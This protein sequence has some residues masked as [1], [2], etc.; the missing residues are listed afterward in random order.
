[1][2]TSEYRVSIHKIFTESLAELRQWFPQYIGYKIAFFFLALLIFTPFSALIF[3]FLTRTSSQGALTNE[4]VLS[5]LFSLRGV[6]S[7]FLWGSFT[8]FS[9]FIEQAGI[10]YICAY[11]QPKQKPP[12][13][14]TLK[15]LHQKR[16][17]ILKLGI[18][19][20]LR[21]LLF[22]LPFLLVWGATYFFLL[23]EYDINFYL[24]KKPPAFWLA[25]TIGGVNLIAYV[26]LL[27][28]YVT[29]WIFVLH[30]LLLKHVTLAEA[31]LTSRKL[32]A[33]VGL[34]IFRLLVVWVLG[35]WV[36]INATSA[37]IAFSNRV[38]VEALAVGPRL[39]VVIMGLLYVGDFLLTTFFISLG[40][41]VLSIMLTKLYQQRLSMKGFGTPSH[42]SE[43]SGRESVFRFVR[44]Q[45]KTICLALGLLLLCVIML[46]GGLMEELSQPDTVAVTAHRGSSKKAPE[47]SLSALRQA[48]EDEADYAEIDVQE[49]ADG[50]IV[51]AHD[52]DLMRVT[53]QPLPLWQTT[54][55]ELKDLDAGSWFSPEFAGERIPALKE[56]IELA[57]GRIK[58]N[59]ELK[60]NGHAEQLTERVVKIVQEENFIE[61]CVISSLNYDAVLKAKELDE[62]LRVGYII[63]GS[64]GKASGVQSDFLSVSKDIVSAAM[65][66][67]AHVGGKE[68]HIWTYSDAPN[69]LERFIYLGVDNIITDYPAAL[70]QTLK[71]RAEMDDFDRL[72]ENFLKWLRR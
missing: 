44:W 45:R 12:L 71:R 66:A 22:S 48:I 4:Y 30:L 33:G 16:S 37:L 3:S 17:V 20:F 53:G 2:N 29:R 47:N 64:L 32:A 25:L 57:R 67:K 39:A 13:V 9:I 5:Y 54:Y 31:F 19:L 40:V 46:G 21:F 15:F 1:M 70:V 41:P 6:I 7:F 26:V 24:T 56:M 8:F 60:F 43:E 62:R 27:L 59:I 68:V 50:V 11:G 52:A 23:S 35:A 55:D 36:F 58:L 34:A 63:Y 69:A 49:T 65:I 42:F 14:N 72:K 51:V 38:I 28:G 18:T 61:H 10:V